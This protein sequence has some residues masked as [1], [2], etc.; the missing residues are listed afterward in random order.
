MKPI[1]NFRH[2][3]LMLTGLLLLALA[4]N[5]P[6]STPDEPTAAPPPAD[7]QATAVPKEPEEP[8]GRTGAVSSLEDVKQA[9]VQ[10]VAE[11]TFIDPEFGLQ[12]NAAGSGSGFII[13]PSGIAVTNNH[14]VTGAALLK[15]YV[16][17]EQEPRNA[18]LLGVSECKDL[19]VIDIEGDG[20]AYLDWFD[21][22]IGVGLQVYA[23]GFPLGDPEFTLTQGIVSKAQ[24]D[25][26]SD[27]ASVNSVLEHDATINPG[28]SG[29]PLVDGNGRIVGINYASSSLFSQYFA[30]SRD[31]ATGAIDQ[32]Q[33]GENVESIGV[34][35]VAVASED[36]TLSG[37]WVAS[38]ASGS[39]ADEAGVLPG[40]IITTLEGLVLATDGSM[41]DYCDILR[42]KGDD[43]TM[44]IEVLRY[45]QGEYLTGQLNGRPLE[46]AGVFGQQLAGDVPD[47]G[48]GYL[49]YTQVTDDYGAIVVEVPSNWIDIDGSAWV[50]AGDVF[51]ASISAAPDLDG[52]FGTWDTPG[53]F[54]AASDDLARWGGYVQ[55]LDFYR[56]DFAAV[57]ELDGRYDYDDGYYRGKYDYFVKCGGSGGADFLILTAVPIDTSVKLLILVEVQ[58]LTN[59]DVDAADRILAT[60]DVVGALP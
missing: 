40:D 42:T 59:D 48:S 57:C 34:N 13:D 38:V 56:P 22:T 46:T 11:G 5:L 33:A 60:F 6:G 7:Q 14:V 15:V 35:G 3:V 36:G 28:N 58:I 4:C 49:E 41:A 23:A 52:F 17:G 54:F 37:I 53:V 55:L 45:Q 20:F 29:G 25:G 27:W 24:A 1:R 16:A 19:A 9:V 43:S 32:L 44:S 10:I 26:E 18:R 47:T 8:T 39:A 50:D 21:G 2:P 51:G 12:V 30:I 31:E